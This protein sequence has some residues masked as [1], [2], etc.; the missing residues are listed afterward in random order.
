MKKTYTSEDFLKVIVPSIFLFVAILAFYNVSIHI[1][2]TGSG[3]PDTIM[4]Y[5]GMFFS[6]EGEGS[7]AS[8]PEETT[9]VGTATEETPTAEAPEG[10]QLPETAEE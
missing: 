10:E 5:R 6:P 1:N 2:H 4:K 3:H 7:G 8:A 9:A